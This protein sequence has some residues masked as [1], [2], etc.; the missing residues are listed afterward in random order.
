VARLESLELL[1]VGRVGGDTFALA[2]RGL[3]SAAEAKMLCQAIIAKIV[4][5][6]SFEEGRAVLSAR[7]GVTS[8]TISGLDGNLLLSHADMALSAAKANPGDAVEI[9]TPAM[10]MRLIIKREMEAALRQALQSGQF[11]VH[12]QPQVS[13]ACGETIGV[14]ALLR[15]RHPALGS[16]SP[17]KFI[18]A[19]EETGLIVEL[20]RFV[21]ETACKE[22]ASWPGQLRLAVNVSPAQFELGDVVHDVQEALAKSGLP[23]DR[24]DLEITEGVFV[25]TGHAATAALKRLQGLGVGVALDDFGTGYSSLSYLGRLPIDTLKIDRS[26]ICNLPGDSEARAIVAAVVTLSHTLGKGVVAEGI[27]TTEQADLLTS[28]G[29]EIGQ[30]YLFGRPVAAEELRARLASSERDYLSAVAS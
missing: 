2:R 21:L 20:G 5:P 10:N 18:P 15:W 4:E 17:D 23:A 1:A 19:A 29:C 24:L 7:A 16:V 12:Y 13:L 9:F 26:F 14:E 6:Y 25:D 27:E 28:L 11:F 3:M 22:V 30:G 8:T